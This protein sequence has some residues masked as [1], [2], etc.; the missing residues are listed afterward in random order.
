MP[1]FFL[2]GGLPARPEHRTH[3]H[4]EIHV[5]IKVKKVEPIEATRIHLDPDAPQGAV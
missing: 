5:K 1:K 3:N 4:W 2:N